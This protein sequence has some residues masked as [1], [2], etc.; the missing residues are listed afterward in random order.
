MSKLRW[1]I[2]WPRI[3]EMLA[4]GSVTP[5]IL[6]VPMAINVYHKNLL[7]SRYG[8]DAQVFDLYATADEGKWVAEPINGMN[9]WWKKFKNTD[10]LDVETGKPVVLR[11]T[12]TD[13]LHSFAIPGI[14]EWR[15]P[16]D[17]EAGKWET[18]TFVPDE[19]DDL[20]FLC[21]QYCSDRHESMNGEIVAR[22][23]EVTE[24]FAVGRY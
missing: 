22:D 5:V 18:V 2:M 11:L 23:R 8:E 7:D 17:V 9:Y 4:L 13:V 10:V 16:I 6:G 12:S 20:T 1:R 24:S 15:R 14:H 19:E 21:W 3:R